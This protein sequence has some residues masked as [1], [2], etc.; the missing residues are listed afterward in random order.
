MEPKML[1]N[2]SKTC[3]AYDMDMVDSAIEEIV[4]YT[5]E[6]D[7]GLAAWLSE[8]VKLMNFKEIIKKLSQ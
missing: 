8:N 5:Y 3:G 4:K 6:N 2:L 7:D 1:Y